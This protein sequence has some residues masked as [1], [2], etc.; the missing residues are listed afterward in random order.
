MD[1]LDKRKGDY[2]RS[3]EKEDLRTE[4][5]RGMLPSARVHED[6]CERRLEF[7]AEDHCRR[8]GSQE[9]SACEFGVGG[10]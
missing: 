9:Q 4:G 2:F 10:S 5:L 6:L 8:P 1:F 7:Q 3:L